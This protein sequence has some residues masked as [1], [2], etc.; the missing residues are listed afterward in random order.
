MGCR[1][2]SAN[3]QR[4]YR[5]PVQARRAA[6]AAE[7]HVCRGLIFVSSSN[8]QLTV[9]RLAH[10]M[11]GAAQHCSMVQ[12]IFTDELRKVVEEMGVEYRRDID[13][14]RL[15]SD[16][17]RADHNELRAD[18]K[19]NILS[20]QDRLVSQTERIIFFDDV[21]EVY[22]AVGRSLQGLSDWIFDVERPRRSPEEVVLTVTEKK[23]LKSHGL[24]Y[25]SRLLDPPQDLPNH[26]NALRLK[27]LGILSPQQQHLCRVLV[28]V[29]ESN[30]ER[31]FL[32]HPRPD[33][34]TAMDR[35]GE[36]LDEESKHTLH[37]F[38][39]TDPKRLPSRRERTQVVDA[40]LF[41]FAE[42]GKY[43]NVATQKSDLEDL[44]TER[45]D[46]KAYLEA[47]ERETV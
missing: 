32:H 2:A 23:S 39:D 22:E 25:L 1:G 24:G 19:K 31:H 35:V 18:L 43:K 21:T 30:G 42:S 12:D 20:L 8:P 11:D 47:L 40:D 4:L 6:G 37:D 15:D 36:Y 33:R 45:A 10:Y 16:R 38:L 14:L 29:Q 44:K 3:V 9:F 26:I 28:D 13:Q 34:D 46:T 7:N 5:D 41:L 17:L 27:A